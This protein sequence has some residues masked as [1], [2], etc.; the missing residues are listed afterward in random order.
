M[1]ICSNPN[2]IYPSLLD[3]IF[4]IYHSLKLSLETKRNSTLKHFHSNVKYYICHLS[5]SE[6]FHWEQKETL[7]ST[8]ETFSLECSEITTTNRTIACKFN[9]I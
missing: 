4:I 7:H 1:Y 5:F 2:E 9:E 3:I 8:D 6:L